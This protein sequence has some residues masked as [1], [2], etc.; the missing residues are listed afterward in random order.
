MSKL[1]EMTE[2]TKYD[3]K[4]KIF[5]AAQKLFVEKGFHNTSMPD[6]V[7]EAGVS[8]GAIYHYFSGKE[9]LAKYIHQCAIKEY[10]SRYE[11]ALEKEQTIRKKIFA[12]TKLMFEWTEKDPNMVEYLLYARPKEILNKKLSICAEEGLIS[13][14]E[15]VNQGIEKKQI[16][17]MDCSVA[18]AIISGT[19][20]RLIELRLDKIFDT[21]LVNVIEETAESIW[22]AIKS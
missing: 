11:F 22:L 5:T 9:E 8:T 3:I 7:R 4:E 6:I 1:N 15:I 2:K 12:Y 20:L 19:L 21:S 17:N 13:V 14:M 18:A 16:R 10:L